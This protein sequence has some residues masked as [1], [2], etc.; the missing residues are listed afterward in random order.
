MNAITQKAYNHIGELT[1]IF[2]DDTVTVLKA[3]EWYMA[4]LRTAEKSTSL[5]TE[6]QKV[7]LSGRY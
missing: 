7:K 6:A 4:A 1:D 2:G 3:I 5:N